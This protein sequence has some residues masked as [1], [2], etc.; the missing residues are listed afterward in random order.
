MVCWLLEMHRMEVTTYLYTR[1]S[2]MMNVG[3]GWIQIFDHHVWVVKILELHYFH[4]S[5]FKEG[6]WVGLVV[7]KK[8]GFSEEEFE[9]FSTRS[10]I[11]SAKHLPK[12]AIVRID[13]Q[14]TIRPVQRI[15]GVLGGRKNYD[16]R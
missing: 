10:L 5:Q 1:P 15:R 11:N 14:S 13:L 7:E 2:R 16:F 4:D 3:R 12:L 9:N 6:K 8:F